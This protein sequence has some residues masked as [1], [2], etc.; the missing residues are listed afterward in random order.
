MPWLEG[1]VAVQP[2]AAEAV[3]EVLSRYAPQRVVVDVGDG[4][5]QLDTPVTVKAYLSVDAEIDVH[6]RQVT[7]AL[8]HLHH[9]W[10][11][12]RDQAVLA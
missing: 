4:D 3:S 10:P 2:E 8:G 6:R 11:A 9:I 7:A 5:L 1:S 12:Y